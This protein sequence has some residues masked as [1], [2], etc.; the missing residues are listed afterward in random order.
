MEKQGL[1]SIL[2]ACAA[3]AIAIAVVACTSAEPF[4]Q[5]AGDAAG[6]FSGSGGQGAG[7]GGTSDDGGGGSASGG[8][9][10]IDEFDSGA[11]GGSQPVD[12]LDAVSPDRSETRDGSAMETL[13]KPLTYTN[14][15]A[16]VH[17]S[18]TASSSNGPDI[19][20]NAI[21]SRP[22]TRWATGKPQQ[23][24]EYLQIDFGGP[25]KFNQ[26][27]LDNRSGTAGDYPRGYG[28]S[29]S[30]DGTIFTN[31]VG[32]VPVNPPGSVLTIALPWAEGRF[33][34]IGQTGSDGTAWWSVNEIRFNCVL[35]TAPGANAVD[36]YDPAY[37][38]GTASANVGG[39]GPSNA[40]DSDLASRWTTGAQQGGSES[41][42]LDLGA[43]T[44]I[45]LIVI[46]SPPTEAPARF[47]IELSS[48]K[49]MFT[50][51]ANGDGSP[52]IRVPLVS[53]TARYIRIKQVGT[54][55]NW[56]S[57]SEIAVKP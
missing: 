20:A 14:Y 56:W 32:P 15:C 26:V 19:A 16:R 8:V 3:I 43:I 48:D 50:A 25:V 51:V 36:P 9:A 49:V 35:V 5:K 1:I 10:G 45:G 40:F 6:A 47:T 27:V 4:R 12:A 31:A 24:G 34:R 37:W 39:S 57:I 11:S 21:D 23:G 7:T 41:F 46:E 33:A 30:N 18:A 42:D 28:I 44:P 13:F 17:W 54:S 29:V 53:W 22:S 52:M 55:M 2:A 38:K